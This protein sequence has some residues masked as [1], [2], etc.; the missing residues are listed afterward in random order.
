MEENLNLIQRGQDI[1]RD[2][3]HKK[4]AFIT[5]TVFVNLLI[6]SNKK[7]MGNCSLLSWPI[8]AL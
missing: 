5:V 8:F 4:I 7:W 1:C 2:S 3:K 6:C